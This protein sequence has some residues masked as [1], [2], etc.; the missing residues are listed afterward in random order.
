MDSLSWGSLPVK[1][2]NCWTL[3]DN[4]HTISSNTQEEE[5]EEEEEKK[6]KWVATGLTFFVWDCQNRQKSSAAGTLEGSAVWR[7]AFMS[8][9][10]C[11][12]LIDIDSYVVCEV[13]L[14]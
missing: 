11:I 2:T 14:G 12:C 4:L 6:M 5:E 8:L 9:I 3:P 10:L 1:L 13:G 7:K